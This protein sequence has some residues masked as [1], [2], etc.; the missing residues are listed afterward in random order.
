MAFIIMMFMVLSYESIYY[1]GYGTAPVMSMMAE[2]HD[3]AA[4][5]N[6][7]MAGMDMGTNG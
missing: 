6:G 4:S 2:S 3:D 7:G 5:S 1:Q